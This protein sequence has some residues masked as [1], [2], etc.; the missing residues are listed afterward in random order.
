[1]CIVY[2]SLIVILEIF[3]RTE[4]EEKL[5]SCDLFSNP[6]FLSGSVHGNVGFVFAALAIKN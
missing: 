6:D 1:M 4:G 2:V 5:K 3:Y